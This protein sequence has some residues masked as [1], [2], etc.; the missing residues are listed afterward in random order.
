MTLAC[1]LASLD[2]VQ[3]ILCEKYQ[4]VDFREAT[5]PL[6]PETSRNSLKTKILKIKTI[7]IEKYSYF[8]YLSSDKGCH[9]TVSCFF[10]ELSANSTS[11]YN[12]L[13][14]SIKEQLKT[15]VLRN[16][17]SHDQ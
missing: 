1:T 10:S 12:F 15:P 17:A 4:S 3:V 13:N 7:I 16:F 14:N 9:N 5:K 2:H 8:L 6:L 11:T